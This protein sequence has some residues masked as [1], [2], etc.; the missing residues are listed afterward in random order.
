M[1]SFLS[2]L[3]VRLWWD[4]IVLTFISPMTGEAEQCSVFLGHVGLF[5]VPACLSSILLLVFSPERLLLSFY[6]F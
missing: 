3:T 4:C 6:V 1:W 2:H 5:S